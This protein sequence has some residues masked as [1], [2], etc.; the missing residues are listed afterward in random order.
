MTTDKFNTSDERPMD[1]VPASA[2]PPEESPLE[3]DSPADETPPESDSA[4]PEPLDELL[5]EYLELRA[6]PEELRDD[7]YANAERAC[8]ERINNEYWRRLLARLNDVVSS[9]PPDELV[10]GPDDEKLFDFGWVD[11]RLFP[12]EKLIS[13]GEFRDPVYTT[14]GLR[15]HLAVADANLLLLPQRRKLAEEVAELRQLLETLAHEVS[16]GIT[17]RFNA[18]GALPPFERGKLTELDRFI[19][20]SVVTLA[21]ME[22]TKKSGGLPG[23][24]MR[25]YAW[26]LS[27]LH[28]AREKRRQILHHIG[29]SGRPLE[30]LNDRIYKL[31]LAA[32][33]HHR[34]LEDTNV[35]LTELQATAVALLPRRRAE[36]EMRLAEIREDITLC[37]RW[38]RTT[39]SPALLQNRDLN[40]AA[41]VIEAIR[42]VEDFDPGLFANRK[43]ERDGRPAVVIT[44]GIGN[45]SYDFRS[46]VLI[47]PRTSPKSLLEASAYALALYRRD[48]DKSLNEGQIWRSFTDDIP[49]G[50]LGGMARSVQAQIRT[51][52]RAYTTWAT[53]E[54]AGQ[55]V[56]PGEIRTWFEAKIAPSTRGPMIPRELRGISLARRAE[57]LEEFRARCNGREAGAE[58]YH[59]LGCLLWMKDDFPK[60]L[61]CFDRARKL[62]SR[63]VAACWGI[64]A[65][66]RLPPDES[67]LDF[68]AAAR[69]ERSV[70]ALQ[71]F[72]SIAEQSWWT[73]RAQS[74]LTEL[75]HRQEEMRRSTA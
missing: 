3:A 50:R 10:F 8:R 59:R 38:G 11:P 6:V 71:A 63:H 34:K 48:V 15:Q 39:A 66:C 70:G 29:P 51:F 22:V 33:Q 57:I 68:G 27:A 47:I 62:D 24:Q 1:P 53:R 44:P 75:R 20:G 32:V 23:E 28:D 49:W 46:N 45:G 74:L 55:P 13:E 12:P 30:A 65:A 67:H 2:P 64:A 9:S 17:Q 52:V 69:L 25:E 40:S 41:A 37:S 61:A 36:L 58:D 72:L 16:T 5:D 31:K 4:E 43:V 73:R 54:A 35:A 56:L 21:N 42:R 19:D 7:D 60:A 14:R 26:L 18:E